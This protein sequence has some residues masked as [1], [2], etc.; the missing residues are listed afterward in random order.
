MRILVTGAGGFIGSHVAAALESAGHRVV[1]GIRGPEPP[2]GPDLHPETLACDFGHDTEV[3][4]WLSRL[5]GVDAVVNCVG[6]LRANR[7]GDFGRGDFG[8]GDFDSVHRAA[9]VALFEACAEAGVAKVVTLR[10]L[11]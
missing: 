4:T 8:R 7:R 6:I 9:P 1:R 10:Q 11:P 2:D 5:D 3:A